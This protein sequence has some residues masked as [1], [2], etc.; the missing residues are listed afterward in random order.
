M[1][2]RHRLLSPSKDPVYMCLQRACIAGREQAGY[3]RIYLR[4]GYRGIVRKRNRVLPRVT[5]IPCPDHGAHHLASE[6][7]KPAKITL[8]SRLKIAPRLC[9]GSLGEL[10]MSQGEG[11]NGAV[12]QRPCGR[13]YRFTLRI[14][15]A[16]KT[17]AERLQKRLLA[18]LQS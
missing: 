17:H 5:A 11:N 10:Q 2:L 9:E 6:L 3:L 12:V 14:P 8:K 4:R 15:P 1:P 18:M 16:V 7:G 13:H